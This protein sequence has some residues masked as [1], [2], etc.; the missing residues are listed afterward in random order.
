L[1]YATDDSFL[2]SASYE[3]H[4]RAHGPSGKEQAYHAFKLSS[5]LSISN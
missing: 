2:Y 1:C 5:S 4:R 3:G